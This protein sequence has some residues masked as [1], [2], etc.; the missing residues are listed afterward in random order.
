MPRKI[1]AKSRRKPRKKVSSWKTIR[2]KR[3]TSHRLKLAA[4][5]LLGVGVSAAF[6]GG[7]YFFQFLRSPLT[8]ASG[9]FSEGRVWDKSTP[10]NLVLLSTD[11]FGKKIEGLVILTA[12]KYQNSVS[13]VS[14]SPDQL[15][16]Y[17]L[18]LGMA[19]LSEAISLGDS[20]SPRIGV[21]MVE[22]VLR[23][24]LAMPID[25]YAV[26]KASSLSAWGEDAVEFKEILRIKNLP[27]FFENAKFVKDNVSTNLSL[28][29]ISELLLF[30][31]GVP[32]GNIKMSSVPSYQPVSDLPLQGLPEFD[33][34]WSDFYSRGVFKQDRQPVLVLNG[35]RREGL[36]TWGGRFVQNIGG[37]LLTAGNAVGNY[38]HTFIITDHPDLPIV[39]SLGR[40]LHVQN[41]YPK[42]QGPARLEYGA[43]RS[44]V[45]LVLGLDE[46]S[47]L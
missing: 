18:G 16:D 11:D 23:K 4:L 2:A 30:L 20:L 43:D 27:R 9:S 39:A 25:R 28:G 31:R 21:G 3:N 46:A 32:P 38:P 42:N 47:N 10:L 35:T 29:E 44:E 34:W 8:L 13:V 7:V 5:A 15:A 14:L 41:I 37:D 6:F 1:P 12:D 26:V 33:A 40:S 17:P 19:P 22:K 24:N 45:T 36:G